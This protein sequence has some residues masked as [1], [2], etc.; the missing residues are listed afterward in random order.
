MLIALICACTVAPAEKKKK[1][2]PNRFVQIFQARIP[3]GAE[4]F[5]LVPGGS[6]FYVMASVESPQFDGVRRITENERVRLATNTGNPFRFYPEYLQFRVSSSARDKLI[7]NDP[8][9][10]PA[11]T[12]LNSFLTGLKFRIK[13]FKGL[14]AR[15]IHPA[16]VEELG[17]PD[18]VPF[19]ER[20]YSVGFNIGKVPIEDRVVMEVVAPSG[21]RLCKFHLD[22]M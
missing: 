7:D 8:W 15:V 4:Q 12:D 10:I 2:D 6:E 21:E 18:D 3:L 13:I 1:T 14:S 19:D 5:K 16:F 20:I 22:L 11:T 9:K 17:V